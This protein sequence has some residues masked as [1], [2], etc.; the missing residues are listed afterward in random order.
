MSSPAG[1]VDRPLDVLMGAEVALHPPADVDE[2]RDA[3]VIQACPPA[4]VLVDVDAGGAMAVR[5]GHVL[6]PLSPIVRRTT[7]RVILLTR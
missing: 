6:Q 7:S 2:A 1:T 4:P 5:G 3:V